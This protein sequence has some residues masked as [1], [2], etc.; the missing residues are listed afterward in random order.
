M[1]R[2]ADAASDFSL[3]FLNTQGKSIASAAADAAHS[4]P[5]GRQ[6]GLI[7]REHVL[8]AVAERM[9]IILMR[10]GT[11]ARLYSCQYRLVELP[12]YSFRRKGGEGLLA[13][14]NID[15][16]ERL[17]RDSHNLLRNQ[18]SQTHDMLDQLHRQDSGVGILLNQLEEKV[19]RAVAALN[20]LDRQHGVNL[21]PRQISATPNQCTP[22]QCHT[23]TVPRQ[24]SATPRQCHTGQ[25]SLTG[26]EV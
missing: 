25:C 12:L 23:K 3:T 10:W 14:G 16:K 18:P 26:K 20:L 15:Q 13:F 22:R 21:A 19:R 2:P 8:A 17:S 1:S 5:L 11:N 7:D 4:E 9:P 24:D 6:L